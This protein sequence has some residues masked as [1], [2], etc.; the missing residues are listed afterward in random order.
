MQHSLVADPQI[1]Q[2][3]MLIYKDFSFDAAHLLPAVPD[4]HPCKQLHGHTYA[5]RVYLKG[6]PDPQLGWIMDFGALK[7]NVGKVLRILDHTY[8]NEVPGLENPTCE[9]VICWI[10]NRLKPELP[11]LAKLE[12]KETP[13]SGAIYEME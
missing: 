7:E 13:T 3:Y 1:V 5:L 6:Q 9:S 12:L 10:W 4:G 11:L 8:L 2:R